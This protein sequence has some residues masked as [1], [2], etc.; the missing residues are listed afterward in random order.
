ME[1]KFIDMYKIVCGL[2]TRP[3][4]LVFREPVDYKGLGLVDYRRYTNIYSYERLYICIFI[5]FSINLYNY[6]DSIE[7][8]IYIVYFYK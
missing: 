5:L 1:I 8:Y 6:Y 4:S 3:E 7:L 2:L